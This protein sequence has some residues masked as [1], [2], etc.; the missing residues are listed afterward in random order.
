MKRRTV[1]KHD[2]NGKKPKRKLHAHPLKIDNKSVCAKCMPMPTNTE[3]R[4][5]KRYEGVEMKNK[6]RG[7][8]VTMVM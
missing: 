8:L 6:K 2:K 1:K 4:A 3:L 7:C 5:D